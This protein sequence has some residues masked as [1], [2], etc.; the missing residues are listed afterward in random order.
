[1]NRWPNDAVENLV[2]ADRCNGAKSDHLVASNQLERWLRHRVDAAGDLDRLAAEAGWPSEPAR[3]LALV[4]T[5]DLSL[6]APRTRGII[7]S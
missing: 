6:P 4:R 5:T 7:G 1:L 3:S 2:A